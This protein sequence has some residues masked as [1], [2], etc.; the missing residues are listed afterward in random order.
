MSAAGVGRP[1]MR[2]HFPRATHDEEWRMGI[3]LSYGGNSLAAF[4][5]QIVAAEG[6]AG[7]Q[8]HLKNVSSSGNTTRFSVVNGVI[9][10][11]QTIERLSEVIIAS[12]D[13][14]LLLLADGVSN[15][16]IIARVGT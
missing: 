12:G 5:I 14:G 6:N 10:V 15:W 2:A 3:G 9:I 7:K 4:L 11:P 1:F 8:I 13:G 16:E